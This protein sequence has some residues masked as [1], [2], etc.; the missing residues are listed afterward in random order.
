MIVLAVKLF[1]GVFILLLN[2]KMPIVGILTFM[3]R[4]NFVVEHEK[5]FITLGPGHVSRKFSSVYHILT[6]KRTCWVG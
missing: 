4:I 3:S 1:V 6:Y 2:V 5:R